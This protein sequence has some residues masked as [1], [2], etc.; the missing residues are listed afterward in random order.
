MAECSSTDSRSELE[1]ALLS[2]QPP[3]VHSKQYLASLK[4]W[5]RRSC[6]IMGVPN[7]FLNVDTLSTNQA[8]GLFGEI[9][10]LRII[11]MPS[12][13]PSQVFIK[14][15]TPKSAERAIQW[16]LET[17]IAAKHGFQR[18]C[19]KHLC[20]KVCKRRNCPNLHRWARPEEIMDADEAENFAPT[21]P[22][23]AKSKSAKAKAK[24]KNK[25]AHRRRAAKNAPQSRSGDSA[26]EFSSSS[27]MGAQVMEM[28]LDNQ[29]AILQQQYDRLQQQ[30]SQQSMFIHNL[31]RQLDTLSEEHRELR[32]QNSMLL[33]QQHSAHRA[34]N[35]HHDDEKRADRSSPET[36]S[37]GAMLDLDDM[38][39]TIV[40][41]LRVSSG[42]S[43]NGGDS[44]GDSN[45]NS[46]G[47]RQSSTGTSSGRQRPIYSGGSITSANE[48]KS[49]TTDVTSVTDSSDWQMGVLYHG[50]GGDSADNQ[51]FGSIGSIG[52]RSSATGA[53]ARSGSSAPSSASSSSTSD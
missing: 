44:N 34:D 35:P 23:A 41:R 40:D 18:Y 32:E 38:V 9:Q 7:E 24:A 33:E 13:I 29:E 1:A 8:F 26:S 4:I 43:G 49:A 19:G 28:S 3:P 17:G 11:H 39:D 16:C 52:S 30:C 6:F 47:D 45:S 12:D 21:K 36:G 10:H 50:G 27:L 37:S 5:D 31:I 2:Q 51:Q 53:M 15:N 46:N 42:D 25:N 22:K 20:G 48:D 14:Y